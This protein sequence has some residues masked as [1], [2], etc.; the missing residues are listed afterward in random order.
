MIKSKD[1][2]ISLAILIAFVLL[3]L[4]A[5]FGIFFIIIIIGLAFRKKTKKGNITA[6][7]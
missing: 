7:N 3:Y 1:Y 4:N 6:K 2:L 5:I